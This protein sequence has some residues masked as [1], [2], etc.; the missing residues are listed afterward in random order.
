MAEETRYTLELESP[1]AGLHKLQELK[2]DHIGGVRTVLGVARDSGERWIMTMPQLT[3]CVEEDKTTG[4][5]AEGCVYLKI[6]KADAEKYVK[7]IVE[8]DTRLHPAV[9]E[10]RMLRSK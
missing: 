5:T 9:E 6:S 10:L 8:I 3:D 7:F 2:A 1:L 4:Y